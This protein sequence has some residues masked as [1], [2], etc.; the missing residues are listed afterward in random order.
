MPTWRRI[1]VS[2]VER[3]GSESAAL[4]AA[5][6]LIAQLIAG[7]SMGMLRAGKKARPPEPRVPPI[8]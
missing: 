8:D 4:D 7:T 5:C 2:L 6:E 3:T 1:K